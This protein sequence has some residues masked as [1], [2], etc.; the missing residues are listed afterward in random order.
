MYYLTSFT[1]FCKYL[2]EHRKIMPFDN[3]QLL[4]S[5]SIKVDQTELEDPR[6]EA[7]VYGGKYYSTPF[8]VYS[9]FAETLEKT[10]IPRTTLW[11]RLVNPNNHEYLMV[12]MDTP[13][14]PNEMCK[15]C[16][17]VDDLLFQEGCWLLNIDHDHN[18]NTPITTEIHYT[19]EFEDY[20][21]TY[22]DWLEGKRPH[23]GE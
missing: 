4:N 12:E 15:F 5:L 13:L 21:I 17:Y 19:Y 23:L 22:Q 11:R 16:D 14:L 8:G 2:Y 7:K 3:I 20:T 9:S 1:L 6:Q 10:G 18:D